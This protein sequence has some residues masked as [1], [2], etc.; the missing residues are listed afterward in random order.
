MKKNLL[1]GLGLGLAL[2]GLTQTTQ[3]AVGDNFQDGGIWYTVLDETAKTVQ[4]KSD[5]D[6]GIG[7]DANADVTGD[8][9]IPSTVTYNSETYTVVAIGDYSFYYGELGNITFPETLTSIGTY[10]FSN[11]EGLLEVTL[12]A[13]ITSLGKG[14]FY[15]C[16]GL[17]TVYY[18]TSASVPQDAFIQCPIKDFYCYATVPPSI[19]DGNDVFSSNYTTNA[20]LYVPE[21]AI[22]TYKQQSLYSYQWNYYFQEIEA[23][24][25]EGEV[26]PLPTGS[27]FSYDGIKYTVLDSEALTV[28]TYAGDGMYDYAN[29]VLSGDVYIPEKVLDK[30]GI[31][32]TVVAIGDFSFYW[33]TSITSVDLPSTLLSI[34]EAAFSNTGISAIT[35]PASVTSIG[36]N[37]FQ[38]NSNLE[39]VYFMSNISSFESGVFLMNDIKMFYIT[40]TTP[41]ALA[42]NSFSEPLSSYMTEAVLYVPDEVV[43]A[44]KNSDWAKFFPTI[45]GINGGGGNVS[46]KTVTINV[47][48]VES[49]TDMSTYFTAT[50]EEFSTEKTGDI[51]FTSASY[52]GVFT[53]SFA[54]TFEPTADY[55]LEVA[56]AESL[57][58]DEAGIAAP[59]EGGSVWGVT[60]F[61]AAPDTVTINVTVKPSTVGVN[62]LNSE[63]GAAAIYN[64]QGV[65]VAEKD[66]H[67]GIFIINGKKVVLK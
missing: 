61:G 19:Y 7:F 58:T 17:E 31:E 35:I 4:T 48:G 36:E 27:N 25:A 16:K 23:L 46:D 33:G 53:P 49:G 20:T 15:G 41:P 38:Q 54:L 30:N 18:K 42:N 65:K 14:C 45:E 57:T 22:A 8:V 29:S 43:D 13:S 51:E 60:I 24:P 34:G 47:E 32:Y 67:N 9:V 2:F 21:E 28:E 10:S 40:N 12:P 66:A 11:C 62:G 26:K 39:E 5:S 59:N 55:T 37:A 52:T 6:E 64:L 44:Y 1:Y 50:Y 3:A 56:F 63:N